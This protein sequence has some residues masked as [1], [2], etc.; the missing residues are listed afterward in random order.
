MVYCRFHV[1]F[2]LVEYFLGTLNK[3]NFPGSKIELL[4]FITNYQLDI[5]ARRNNFIWSYRGVKSL[6]IF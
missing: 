4:Y 6:I 1:D 2:F 3:Q 5:L